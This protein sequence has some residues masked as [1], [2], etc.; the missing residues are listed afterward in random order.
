M[1]QG[2]ET[3]LTMNNAA[4]YRYVEATS[5]T[6]FS[7]RARDRGLQALFITLCRYMCPE[8]L[9]NN[10]AGNFN[11]NDPKIKEIEK[12]IYNYVR[13][14]DEREVDNVIKEIK[15]IEKKWMTEATGELWYK[16]FKK[17]SLLQPDTEE[18]NRFRCMNSMR[19]VEKQSGL[20][21][22]GE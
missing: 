4:M 16:K 9:E 17:K 20:Y 6:P 1:R 5:L 7:D 13:L 18:E 22:L 2:P 8:L 15:D 10:A 21:L 14:V 3:D 19:S 12:M 11:S